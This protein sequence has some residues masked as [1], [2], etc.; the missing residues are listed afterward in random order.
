MKKIYVLVLVMCLGYGAMSQTEK[1]NWLI[2]G[3]FSLNTVSNNT[4][5]GLNPT[6]GYFIVNNLAIGATF[7]LEHEKFGENRT[8]TFGAGP[9]TRYYLGKTNVKPFLHGELNLISE[10]LKFPGGTNTENGVNY[11]LAGGLALFLNE[12]V[13]LEGLAGYNHTKIKG[14]EGDGGFA[15]RIGFQ[16]YLHPNRVV[17]QIQSN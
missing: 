4:S 7:M 9:L 12:N 2:G 5:I 10:K 17:D 8:T 3:T 15:M 6:F 1:G 14:V 11:F 16:V 13:A